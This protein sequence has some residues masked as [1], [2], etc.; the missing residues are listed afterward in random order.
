MNVSHDLQH[1]QA[2]YK[3]MQFQD[4]KQ[5]FVNEA[6]QWQNKVIFHFDR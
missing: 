1:I 4:H 3:E 5:R 2:L 6:F